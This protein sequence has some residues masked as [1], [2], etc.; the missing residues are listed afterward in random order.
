M[1]LL[2]I[3]LALLLSGCAVPFSSPLKDCLEPDGWNLVGPI[4]ETGVMPTLGEPKPNDASYPR[5]LVGIQNPT[6]QRAVPGLTF[7]NVRDGAYPFVLSGGLTEAEPI[8]RNQTQ[9]LAFTPYFRTE[10]AAVDADQWTFDLRFY[11]ERLDADRSCASYART[12][13]TFTFEKRA[14]GETARPGVGV[15]VHTAGFW[16]NGTL[17]YTNMDRVHNDTRIPHAGWYEYEGGDPLSVYIYNESRA[18]RPE[19]YNETGFGVTIPGFNEALK[20]AFVGASR[21]ARLTP[22]QA[23]THDGNEEHLLY[24]DELVFYIEITDVVTVD[25][26]YPQPVCEV[27]TVPPASRAAWPGPEP[28]RSVSPID[29]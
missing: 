28:A 2:L 3:T 19:R 8:G 15:L 23:Y 5:V 29:A 4:D 10:D 24:G 25:C 27:P 12:V 7:G 1:R 26:P 21:V 17:F 22:E 18:E 11:L 13:D 14:A 9:L 16:L 20:E 6:D